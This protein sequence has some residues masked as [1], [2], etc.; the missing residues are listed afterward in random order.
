MLAGHEN[1]TAGMMSTMSNANAHLI[2]RNRTAMERDT[3][4]SALRTHAHILPIGPL[5]PA[6]I[7][8]LDQLQPRFDRKLDVLCRRA[9]RL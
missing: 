6:L 4:S 3:S 9:N 8:D 1:A 5:L 7:N 2:S